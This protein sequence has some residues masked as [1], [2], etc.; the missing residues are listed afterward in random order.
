MALLTLTEI[1]HCRDTQLT[2]LI[3]EG[4]SANQDIDSNIVNFKE[5]SVAFIQCVVED[6]NAD[7][8]TFQLLVSNIK[9]P[10]SF[11]NRDGPRAKDAGCNGLGWDVHTF[12]WLYARV[13]YRQNTNTAGTVKVIAR[14]KRG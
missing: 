6:S 8:Y 1:E 14:A 4:T 7:D 12:G 2:F 5:M 11:V 10:N 9:D 13:R 3:P